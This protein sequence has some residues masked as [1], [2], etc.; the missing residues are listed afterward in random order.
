MF[1]TQ[2]KKR[3]KKIHSRLVLN[4]TLEIPLIL[5]L[6]NNFLNQLGFVDLINRSVTWD[7]KQW[8]V[9]PGNLAKAII[10]VT[11]FKVRAPLYII[12]NAFVGI[13]TETL[14][15]KGV[16]PE[17]LNDYALAR[18][19]DR[20]SEA[21]AES[22]FSSFALSV[23]MKF[24]IPMKRLHSDTTTLS[25]YGAFEQ[26]ETDPDGLQINYGYNKDH[27][28]ECKQVVVG[29]IVNEHGIAVINSTMNGNTSDIEW[30][31]KALGLLKETFGEK[32][33][34]TI[35]IADSKL[36][37]LPTLK[38]LRDIVCPI[39]FI[40]RCPDNF[41]QK[42]ANKMI[43]KA[44]AK[45]DWREVGQMSKAKKAS[46]YS[47][48]DFTADV[49]GQD[50]RFVVVKT[51]EGKGRAER[52][53]LKQRNHLEKGIKTLGKKIFVCE[54]DAEEEWTR[55]QKEFRKNLHL[56]HRDLV[57]TETIKRPRGNP[58][59]N[60]PPP[61]IEMTWNVS[62]TIDGFDEERFKQL[63]Q[64]K[65]CF[66]LITS[67]S[68]DELDQEQVLRQ[69]KAQMVVECQFH[70]LKQPAL[71]SVIFLKTPC[72]IDALVMLLNVSLLIR[73]LMQY[74]IRKSMKESQEEL[75]RIGVNKGVLKN[76][77]TN[78]L[79]E[80]LNKT[81]LVKEAPGH[82]TYLLYNDYLALCVKTFFQ[83]LEVDMDD[84][85]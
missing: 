69:Y 72:R 82:Y 66:V 74:K 4:S 16:L 42:I 10:L 61:V 81:A 3:K 34:E 79:I 70:L 37:N 80:A 48:Q 21:K 67:V 55:F 6:V 7:E 50:L 12:Q 2:K 57:K 11:F 43:T 64:G 47:T 63:E 30:N 25:F 17:H 65:E 45:N 29:K 13:D 32:L 24:A 39:R 62:V 56:T 22:L 9:S 33:A 27:L 35:Y 60:P 26:C 36:I 40:S 68:V 28:P 71:A 41:Y 15:G 73:G 54:D 85:F 75:P 78:Y 58:G 14:F 5:I 53:L 20:I 18:A 38:I 46:F 23:Y 19:L 84:P 59:K 83:L 77:T 8:Q 51:S 31:Q 1:M 76:P 44:Y 49:D 52:E